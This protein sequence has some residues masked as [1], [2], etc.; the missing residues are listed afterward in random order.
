MH[1]M[2][3]YEIINHKHKAS[4]WRYNPVI[5]NF[6]LEFDTLKDRKKKEVSTPQI[7]PKLDV[8]RW[9][10]IFLDFLPR[11]LGARNVPFSLHF[12]SYMNCRSHYTFRI[13]G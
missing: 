3:H 7:S 1:I 10:E 12:A 4:Q 13:D 8:V 6:K 2:R 11:I 9:M 5:K